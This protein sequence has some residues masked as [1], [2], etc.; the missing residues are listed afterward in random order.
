MSYNIYMDE[1][2]FRIKE[3]NFP[4]LIKAIVSAVKNG[5]IFN[6]VTQSNILNASNESD[7]SR[8][9]EKLLIEC[10]WEPHFNLKR[11]ICT[12]DFLGTKLG[13]EDKLFKIMAPYVEA[14]SY[15]RVIGEEREKWEWRFDGKN[16]EEKYA[17]LDWDN[18]IEIVEAILKRKKMLPTLLGIHPKLDE[19]IG[20]VLNDD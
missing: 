5:M 9:I 13:D 8:A 4:H 20:R 3:K 10:R 2:S 11:N 18:N 17:S 1:C 16:V 19:R 7:T 14:G 15:I 6:C 12:I